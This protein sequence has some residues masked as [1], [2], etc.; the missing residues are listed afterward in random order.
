MAD[1]GDGKDLPEKKGRRGGR[2]GTQQKRSVIKKY[3]D[4]TWERLARSGDLRPANVLL[5][6]GFV[7]ND[8]GHCTQIYH[9]PVSQEVLAAQAKLG[10]LTARHKRAAEQQKLAKGKGKSASSS[11][12]GGA[13]DSA[14]A[15]RGKTQ[16]KKGPRGSAHYP[17]VRDQDWRANPDNE[18]QS[19]AHGRKRERQAD[20]GDSRPRRDRSHPARRVCFTDRVRRSTQTRRDENIAYKRK[21]ADE[22]RRA[23]CEE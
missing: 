18:W 13:K 21:T 2:A 12:K 7:F 17:D 19:V 11:S 4:G 8:L 14:K 22:W 20:R 9:E 6:N 10:D 3:E 5:N 1:K 15:G 23:E 16:G